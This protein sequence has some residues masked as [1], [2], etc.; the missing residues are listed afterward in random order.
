MRTHT[1]SR[2][3]LTAV[4][5]MFSAGA[6]AQDVA[7]ITLDPSETTV[8][9][10]SSFYMGATAFD[11]A[12]QPVPDTIFNWASTNPAVA[13]VDESGL[14]MA[15]AAGDAFIVATAENGVS[16]SATIHVTGA[17]S[18]STDFHFNEIHYDN[19]GIDAGETIEIEGPAGAVVTGFRIVLYNGNGGAPYGV[20]HTLSGMIPASCGTRGV[21]TFSYPTDGIQNGSPDGM[22]LVNAQGNVIEFLSYEGT[23]T[24]M[25][26]VAAGISL[27]GHSRVRDQCARWLFTAAECG[28]NMG[29][30]HLELRRLQFGSADSG[31]QLAVIQWSCAQRSGA[32]RGFRRPALRNA[33]QPF[34]RH[35]SDH[36]HLVFRHAGDRNHR[37]E[38]RDACA[39]R[40]QRGV[41]CDC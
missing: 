40:G 28:W 34:Q 37:F 29:S 23:F 32:A 13:T 2:W 24:A 14:V 12:N 5:L 33:P 41:A 18:T 10:D 9:V 4:A 39:R 19:L 11:I 21:L 20:T 16:G 35:D 25:S 38:R 7:S 26:G 31:G 15:V 22:A 27:H 36:H 1:V 6:A 8:S 30:G 17:P 3:L